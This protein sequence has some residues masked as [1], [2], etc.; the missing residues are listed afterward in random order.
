MGEDTPFAHRDAGE[1][2]YELSA[3]YG[4]FFDDT[5]DFARKLV[6]AD[7]A[8]ERIENECRERRDSRG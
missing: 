8:S 5:L 2:A 4:Q 7:G 6:V 3:A 1:I